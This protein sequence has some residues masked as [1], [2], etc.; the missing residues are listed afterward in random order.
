MT[1][2][3]AFRR[4]V[5]LAHD[6]AT[7]QGGIDKRGERHRIEVNRATLLRRMRQRGSVRPLSGSLIEAAIVTWS[8]MV[9]AGYRTSWSQFTS[10]CTGVEVFPGAKSFPAT[11][12]PTRLKSATRRFVPAGTGI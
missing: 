9:S 4:N 8:A 3:D 7:H 11:Y 10:P 2:R 1:L 12:S 6:G 5:E